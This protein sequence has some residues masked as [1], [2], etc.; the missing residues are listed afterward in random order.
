MASPLDRVYDELGDD[1]RRR[2][3]GAT[4][5]RPPDLAPV[6]AK[7]T[8]L[9]PGE[10][11]R[12]DDAARLLHMAGFL[13]G[14][15]GAE[16]PL[17]ARPLWG[18]G[19]RVAADH[20]TSGKVLALLATL[21]DGVR[22]RSPEAVD[23]GELSTLFERA[24]SLDP[25]DPAVFGR[26]GL[27]FLH[28]GNDDAAERC[29]TRSLA[30]DPSSAF[31]AGQ[32]ADLLDHRGRPADGFAILDRAARAMPADRP[33]TDLLWKA[34][35]AAVAVG[36]PDAALEHLSKL[37]PMD[38]GRQWVPYYR[39]TSL[40]DLNRPAEAAVAIEREAGL[41]KIHDALHVSAVRAAAAA[42]K[43]DVA[44]AR[45]HIDAAVRVPLSSCSYLNAAGTVGCFTRLWTAARSLADDDTV[46]ARLVQRML[47]SGLTP[48]PFWDDARSAEAEV[49]GLMLFWVDVRQP[50][51]RAWAEA[52]NALPKTLDWTAYGIRY[53]VLAHD[54]DEARNRVLDWQRRS[55]ELAPIVESVT[56]DGGPQRGRP[57]VTRRGW[58]ARAG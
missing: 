26:A 57:G 13:S 33:N 56:A 43:G 39:A 1:I 53:G 58:P 41:I 29:L 25:D 45:R 18:W 36:R 55:A 11:A 44:G 32:L 6:V 3:D 37:E 28:G 14:F 42:A 52:G 12:T 4:Q 50:L 2:L 27:F 10:V 9:P 8:A 20:P 31:L 40:L 38:P 23:A 35:L 47:D 54:A 51:D 22:Q 17:D 46:K 24:M 5:H 19:R 48:V 21:G 16:P 15:A 34:G 49:D 7:L 30:L